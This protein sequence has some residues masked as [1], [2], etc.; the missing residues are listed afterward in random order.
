MHGDEDR[1]AKA[2]LATRSSKPDICNRRMLLCPGASTRRVRLGPGSPSITIVTEEHPKAVWFRG[3]ALE[4]LRLA[5][6]A[7]DVR[8]K[9]L[10]TVEAERWLRL[11]ELKRPAAELD[12]GGLIAAE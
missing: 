4:C 9:R 7:K 10:Y 1:H 8:I 2:R 3:R 11:S 12:N 5:L 6:R